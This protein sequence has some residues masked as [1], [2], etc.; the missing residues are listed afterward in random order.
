LLL[1][2]GV[3]ALLLL[4]CLPAYL[5]DS[6]RHHVPRRLVPDPQQILATL[7]LSCF[8]LLHLSA[9]AFDIGVLE[10]PA[11]GCLAI[12]F[13]VVYSRWKSKRATQ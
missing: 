7:W 10:I 1:L 8:W 12:Q 6:L 3:N 11:L 5:P 4:A 9:V 13:W 2:I